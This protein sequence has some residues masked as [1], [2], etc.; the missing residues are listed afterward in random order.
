[1]NIHMLETG[2]CVQIDS[3]DY[4]LLEGE[5]WWV[6]K[7]GYVKVF[8]E[9]PPQRLARLVMDAKP[10]QIVD[11][12]DRNPLNNKRSNLR[13][14]DDSQSSSNQQKTKRPSTSRFKGV[15]RS[16]PVRGSKKS[17]WT[18]QIS[19]RG[20]SIYLGS[21][22]NEEDAARAYDASAIQT[23]GEFAATNVTLGLLPPLA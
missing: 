18:A 3:S 11:H 19:F 23:H 7:D 4:H 1:M 17:P 20:K 10:G 15:F 9:G 14:C 21:F 16:N 5:K 8:A 12:V 2:H 13:F 6:A 22:V